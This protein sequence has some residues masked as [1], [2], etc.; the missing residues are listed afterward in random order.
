MR[1]KAIVQPSLPRHSG[2]KTPVR[3][4][5]PFHLDILEVADAGRMRII[6]VAEH[7][8]VGQMHRCGILP[9][10]G[11]DAGEVDLLVEPSSHPIVADVSDEV[12]EVADVLVVARLQP[13]APRSPPRRASHPDP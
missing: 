12:R 3:V 5:L 1:P 11:V 13:I 10:L 6:A 8:D 2:T 9:N 7:G 4:S